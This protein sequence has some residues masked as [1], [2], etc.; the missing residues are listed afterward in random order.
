[1]S[2][3]HPL[4]VRLLHCLRR[5]ARMV[6]AMARVG[7]ARV[8]GARTRPANKYVP[9]K[10]AGPVDRILLAGYLHRATIL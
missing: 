8:A 2:S 7:L 9:I 4:S 1:M 6:Q 3:L 5:E 10:L